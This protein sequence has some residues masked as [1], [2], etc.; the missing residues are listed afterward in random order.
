MGMLHHVGGFSWNALSRLLGNSVM[1]DSLHLNER[2]AD[3]VANTVTEW[4]LAKGISPDNK[5]TTR[6]K[7]SR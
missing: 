3:I 7:K 6:S 2:G 1:S 5:A 4:L